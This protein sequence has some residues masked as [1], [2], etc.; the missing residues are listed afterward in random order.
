MKKLLV[1]LAVA[2][3][4]AG[5][6]MAA[7]E[8]PSS[9]MGAEPTKAPEQDQK[10]A[11]GSTETIMAIDLRANPPTLKVR[12][13]G[14]QTRTLALDLRRTSVTHDGRSATLEHLKVGQPVS[15]TTSMEGGREMA[16][17]IRV[18]EAAKQQK[19]LGA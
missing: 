2:M 4:M 14:G 1:L 15:V 8:A 19:E 12:G 16:R 5:P 18:G 6:V 7:V 17:S 3:W 9:G 13:E 10:A 11:A